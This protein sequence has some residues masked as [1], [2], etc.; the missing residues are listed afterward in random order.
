MLSTTKW[1]GNRQ[2]MLLT[3]H[4]S[5]VL[6]TLVLLCSSCGGLKSDRSPSSNAPLPLTENPHAF[7][8]ALIGDLPYNDEQQVKFENLQA[9]LNRSHLKFIIHDG[10]FKGGNVLC[11]NEIYQH[12]LK[13]F[14]HF[15]HPL[16][17]V[18]GDNEWTDCHRHSAGAY[19]PFER[20]AL[21][22]DMFANYKQ[23][24][25]FGKTKLK[26]HRQ[27]QSF[28]ENLR[29]TYANVMFVGLHIPGSNNGLRTAKHL[30]EQAATCNGPQT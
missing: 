16:I 12:R 30:L 24:Y 2:Q 23:P 13:S 22:R 27:S 19:N 6:I 3:A 7:S 29:W 5:I 1:L 25:S 20:L 10:D 21:L 4:R 15:R 26:L 18:F 17:Y 11:D 28:P 8:F 14:N 9:E